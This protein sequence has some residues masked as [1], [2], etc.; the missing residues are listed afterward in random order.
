MWATPAARSVPPYG[1]A[2]TGRD[3]AAD[4][5]SWLMKWNG[6]VWVD[7]K[8]RPSMDPR[9]PSV[10]CGSSMSDIGEP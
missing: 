3:G 9:Q 6:T 2:R 7:S 10:Q 4:S 5:S 1:T 8:K